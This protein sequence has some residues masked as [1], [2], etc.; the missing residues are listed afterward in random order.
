MAIQT[1]EFAQVRTA[2][3]LATYTFDYNDVTN[4]LI[5]VDCDNQA[6][7]AMLVQENGTQ[8]SAPAGQSTN[9]S[10][11]SLSIDVE[12]DGEGLI[13]PVGHTLIAGTG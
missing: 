5:G 10:L 8:V 2:S 1:V 7:R 6:G 13:K 9:R 4:K 3:G 12:D 11:A